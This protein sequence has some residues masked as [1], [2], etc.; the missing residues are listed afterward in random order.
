[1][2]RPALYI[3]VIRSQGLV[4]DYGA[5]VVQAA[6]GIRRHMRLRYTT[7]S[8]AALNPRSE[9]RSIDDDITALLS[10]IYEYT[11]ETPNNH[12]HHQIISAFLLPT[13]HFY[14]LQ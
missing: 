13:A 7:T 1:M 12:H 8:C 6:S 9:I 5:V 3:L 4:L 2:I 11:A 10:Y 14:T